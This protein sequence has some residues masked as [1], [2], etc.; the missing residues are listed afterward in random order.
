MDT[1]KQNR[2]DNTHPI[3]DRNQPKRNLF[4]A[5]LGGTDGV[6]AGG[7]TYLYKY[8]A[9]DSAEYEARRKASTIDGVVA[10]GHCGL[11]GKVFHQDPD[12]EA[13]NPSIKP[14]L[15][16]IDNEGNHFNVFSRRAFES[17]FDGHS[18]IVIDAPMPPAGVQVA[19]LEDEQRLGIRPVWK[20]Y[21][22]K[23]VINWRYAVDP[24]T[25]K[26]KLALLVLKEV[27][28]VEDGPFGH[29]TTEHYRVYRDTGIV[30]Q[31][32]WRKKEQGDAQRFDQPFE[33]LW[34]ITLPKSTAIPAAIIGELDAEPWLLNEARLEIKAYQKE[35]SF[36]VIEYLSIPVFYT[37]G[38]D[39]EE[40]I[41]LG[42]STHV[43]L[44]SPSNGG[45]AEVGFAQI[46]S[47]G[48]TSLKATIDGIKQ[49]I[50]G[51][52]D[53]LSQETMP[54]GQE[55]TATEVVSDD[56]KSQARLI[57]WAGQLKDALELALQ[58]TAEFMGMPGDQGGEITLMT[59]WAVRKAQMEEA[60]KAADERAKA[61]IGAINATARA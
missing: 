38:Y 8:P 33:M 27:A 58:F 54:T 2:V 35:S 51:K 23:D 28:E 53:A 13:V 16:N 36:D 49:E 22:A 30:T 14:L 17:A 50:A 56:S 60:K 7:E 42:A 1:T 37:V 4:S 19:S 11:V 48:H 25:N 43:R 20:L 15:E 55:Q 41:A 32:L 18:V 6:Q 44:P 34:R 52:L 46:D 3:Y 47:A 5:V 21:K 12:I 61:E 59:A 45:A 39:K 9:E 26:T 57:V 40:P 29:K 24:I 10:D 31:E